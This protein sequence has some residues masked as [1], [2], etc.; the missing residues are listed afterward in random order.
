[1][2]YP[3]FEQASC[4]GI[5]ID[6]FYTEDSEQR[7]R[8]NKYIDVNYVKKICNACPVQVSCLDWGLYHE[9]DGIWGGLTHTEREKVRKER[10]IK[11]VNLLTS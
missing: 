7:G 3:N 9:A 10:G 1:M 6:F 2:K 8:H 5:G 4:R 11:Y